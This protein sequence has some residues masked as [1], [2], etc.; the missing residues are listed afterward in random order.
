M[1]RQH[2]ITR[3]Q[4]FNPS[5]RKIKEIVIHCSATE[6]GGDFDASDIDV[7]HTE[8]GFCGI[9]YHFVIRLDGTIEEGRPLESAGAHVSGHNKSSI[10][11]CYIGGLEKKTKKAKDTRTAEQKDSLLWLITAIRNNMPGGGSMTVKGH[12]DYSPD[13]N[14]NGVIDPYE[15]IKE[16]PCFDATPEYSCHFDR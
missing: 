7:W 15:R 6:E 8:R 2:I 14:K 1:E 5:V 13:K 12:R 16:C 4:A 11:I 9:G 3:L 10:G